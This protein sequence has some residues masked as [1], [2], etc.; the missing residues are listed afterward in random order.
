MQC[1]VLMFC[2]PT[3]SVLVE[4]CCGSDPLPSL[5][6]IATKGKVRINS[7][8]CHYP[9]TTQCTL[10][11]RCALDSNQ[12]STRHASQPLIPTSQPQDQK[13]APNFVARIR[14]LPIVQLVAEVKSKP[15]D[16]GH[17][18]SPPEDCWY[19][20]SLGRLKEKEGSRPKKRRQLSKAKLE[21]LWMLF[22][23]LSCSAVVL[24]CRFAVVVLSCGV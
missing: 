21:C 16:N 2:A 4:G 12:N 18:H 5:E 3:Q 14:S 20:I 10:L 23:V 13:A 24:P 11:D 6:Q 1:H 15:K 8:T 22:E 19:P 9:M 7:C 17:L